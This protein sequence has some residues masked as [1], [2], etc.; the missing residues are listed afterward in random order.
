MVSAMAIWETICG[1]FWYSRTVIDAL[2]EVRGAV[3]IDTPALVLVLV[4]CTRVARMPSNGWMVVFVSN[5][6]TEEIASAMLVSR[7][8]IAWVSCTA[9]MLQSDMVVDAL[10]I[11]GPGAES[12]RGDNMFSVV[13]SNNITASLGCMPVPTSSEEKL[14]LGLDAC[15]CSTTAA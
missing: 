13:Y 15:L 12:C 5:M 1:G 10:V 7:E 8:D 9:D 3:A 6:F 14:L 11:A 4:L 2:A